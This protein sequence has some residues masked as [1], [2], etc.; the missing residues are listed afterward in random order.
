[1]PEKQH[2]AKIVAAF[3]IR[4]TLATDQLR[5][6]IATVHAA[7]SNVESAGSAE[8]TPVEL[9]PAVPIRRSITPSSII[10][11]ECGYA[12]KILKSHL[13]N[14][15]GLTPKAYRERWSLR[16]NYPMVAASY[17]ARRSELA[18][19]LGLGKGGR[20]PAKRPATP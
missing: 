3:V 1:M 4:N 18:K 20:G 17:A 8:L 5:G 2:V 7:L 9:V 6:L 14:A 19:S 13:M 11:L 15:H 12:R 10:C 16:S